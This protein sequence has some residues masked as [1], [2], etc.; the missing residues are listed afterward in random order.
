MGSF[1]CFWCHGT[2]TLCSNR[3]R[4]AGRGAQ[5]RSQ[6]WGVWSQP[7]SPSPPAS[8]YADS[9]SPHSLL[10]RG[11]LSC[12]ERE[13][14]NPS[15]KHCADFVNLGG[16]LSK[17]HCSPGMFTGQLNGRKHES[18]TAHWP[19]EPSPVGAVRAHILLA[20]PFCH[21]KKVLN[22]HFTFQMEMSQAE[23]GASFRQT[24]SVTTSP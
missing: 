23:L 16:G 20:A 17:A 8:P 6:I 19:Q 4:G 13:G 14:W 3:W 7:P 9:S 12:T 10:T 15:W 2:V 1:R 5:H 18:F 22:G 11:W 24:A 21:V